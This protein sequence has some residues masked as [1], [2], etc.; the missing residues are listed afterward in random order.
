MDAQGEN[1]RREEE[2]ERRRILYEGHGDIITQEDIA[3]WAET[4]KHFERGKTIKEVES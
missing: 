4:K 3:A 1:E 2:T